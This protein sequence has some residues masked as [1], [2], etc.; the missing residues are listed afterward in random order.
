MGPFGLEAHLSVL[1]N[2]KKYLFDFFFFLLS[3]HLGP[4]ILNL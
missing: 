3:L 2:L 1:G 4:P